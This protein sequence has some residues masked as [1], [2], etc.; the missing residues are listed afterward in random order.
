MELNFTSLQL[1]RKWSQYVEY[2]RQI[3]T[4]WP[5]SFS[6]C[7]NCQR[8]EIFLTARSKT[9]HSIRRSKRENPQ[10]FPADKESQRRAF[11]TYC[12]CVSTRYWI[13]IP[14]ASLIKG[15]HF[16]C[17]GTLDKNKNV[18]KPWHLGNQFYGIKVGLP[19][20]LKLFSYDHQTL[21]NTHMNA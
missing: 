1:S 11:H 3:Q 16:E 21:L 17:L 12:I 15:C 5:T 9:A 19:K 10:G 13:N 8:E 2:C 7:Y 4:I 18:T 6:V 14:Q 20:T